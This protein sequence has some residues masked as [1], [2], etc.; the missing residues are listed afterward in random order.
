M[1]LYLKYRPQDFKSVVGQEHAVTTIQ[2][3]IKHESLTHAYLFSGPRGTGKTSL[4]RIIAK[5]LNCL[6][7][8]V[9]GEPCNKCSICTGI[10]EGRLVDMI[11]IDAASNRGIDEIRD[12]REKIVFAPNQARTKVYIIDEVHMLTKEAFNALLKTLEEPPSHAY[13]I[14]ATTEAHKIPETIVSRCQQFNFKRINQEAIVKRLQMIAEEEHIDA[15]TEAL[16]LI[17]KVANGGLRDAIGLFEQMSM[18]GSV[19]YNHV[20]ENLGLSSAVFIEKFFQNL[21]DRKAL[22]AIEIIN[23]INA[24]GHNLYQ[25]ANEVIAYLREQMLINLE[26]SKET[27]TIIGFIDIFSEAKLQMNQAL[28]PQLPLE[29]AVVR[30]CKF[31]INPGADDKKKSTADEIEEKKAIKSKKSDDKTTGITLGEIKENWQRI[32]DNIET[33][34]IRMSFV[35]GEPVKF[36]NDTLHLV[37]KSETLMDKIAKINNQSVVL[38]AFE[39]VLNSKIKLNLEI[40]KVNLNPVKSEKELTAIKNNGNGPSIIEMAEEVFGIKNK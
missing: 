15:D 20:A 22:K 40:K 34:Y 36:E 8:S 27:E 37:F 11:E 17:A 3:A 26:N 30:A 1:S 13:F 5:A 6:Q 14:L 28:I 10:N 9:D 21:S 38:K 12:L 32:L 35:D 18:D 23:Q 4:A 39:T 24:Q 29:V 2:N 33:P 25:F 31:D 16:G 7:R 19:R